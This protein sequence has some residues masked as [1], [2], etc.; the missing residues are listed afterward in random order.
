MFR[1]LCLPCRLLQLCS[2]G[3]N[4][5]FPIKTN[6]EC[7]KYIVN[8]FNQHSSAT[9]KFVTALTFWSFH[10]LCQVMCS[11]DVIANAQ[12]DVRP[13]TWFHCRE[14][15]P[16][17][18][19][20]VAHCC[21]LPT[22]YNVLK[23][24]R[25]GNEPLLPLGSTTNESFHIFTCSICFCRPLRLDTR[26]APTETCMFLQLSVG[27][28]STFSSSMDR[29]SSPRSSWKIIH[30]VKIHYEMFLYRLLEY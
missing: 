9:V 6:V 19:I 23:Y 18:D 7:T 25:T 30:S 26:R 21:N 13:S 29:H 17:L 1:T 11:N 16:L 27:P 15:G 24:R 10:V 14:R 20:T 4:K 12:V 3:V 5:F 2:F 22:V 28:F 8:K